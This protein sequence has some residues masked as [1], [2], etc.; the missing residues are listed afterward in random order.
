MNLGAAADFTKSA[1]R[2]SPGRKSRVLATTSAPERKE[3]TLSSLGLAKPALQ[4]RSFTA[5][6]NSRQG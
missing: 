5:V 3:T 6:K 4:R 2:S 1:S